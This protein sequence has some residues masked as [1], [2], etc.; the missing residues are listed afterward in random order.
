VI[1]L[2]TSGLLAAI[3]SSQRRHESARQVLES[4]E[5]PFLLS[6]F[7]LAELDYLLMTR[8][9]TEAELLFL[10]DV[11]EGAYRL[12]G[13]GPDEVLEAAEL[14]GRYRDLGIGL[15]DASIVVIAAR[16]GTN[17]ILTLDERHFRAMRPL[18]GRNFALLPKN[19][20]RRS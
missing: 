6:P 15:A 3:D 19:R 12:E 16:A 20:E 5:G 14:I 13:F 8:V 4:E 18:R 7:V 2:D 9:G 10:R 1:V 17:R 11:A